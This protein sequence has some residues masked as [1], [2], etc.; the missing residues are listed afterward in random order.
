MNNRMKGDKKMKPIIGICTNYSTNEN[1]GIITRLGFAGQ[2]WHLVAGDYIRAVERGGGIP[3][4][5]PIL[6]DGQ[7]V[8]AIVKKID[9]IIFTGGS[10]IDPQYYGELPQYGLGDINPER[11]KQEVALAKRVLYE[12]DIPV[13]GICRGIQLLTVAS[14]G[15]LYQDLKSQRKEGFNH[16]LTIAPKYH[17]THPVTIEKGSRL[18]EIFGKDTLGINGFNHQAVKT[19]GEN[20]KATMIAPDGL[21]EGM[22]LPGERFVVGVQWHPE[23]MIDRY[24]EYLSLFRAFVHS[25]K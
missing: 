1:L 22:E 10:D 12:T 6:E 13:L 11:D 4:I 7:N 15:T 17:A 25:C 5:I 24:P 19:L 2:D 23:M 3:V 20:F 16:T 8:E 18:H 14:G 21:V 9:G